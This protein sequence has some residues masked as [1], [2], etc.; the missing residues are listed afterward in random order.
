MKFTKLAIFLVVHMTIWYL[1]A[2]LG[3]I[4]KNKVAAINVVAMLSAFY[5]MYIV[6]MIE[7]FDKGKKDEGCRC[8]KDNALGDN[9]AASDG[10]NKSEQIRG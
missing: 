10:S 7:K 5:G 3:Y 4:I 9:S 2:I 6:E 8:F 1:I